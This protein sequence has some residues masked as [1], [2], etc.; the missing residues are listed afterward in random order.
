[1]DT[2]SIWSQWHGAPMSFMQYGQVL[3]IWKD[4]SC[5]NSKSSQGIA[6]PLS[7]LL[8]SL[9]PEEWWR[10]GMRF[11]NMADSLSPHQDREGNEP[12][13]RREWGGYFGLL[14][15]LS[16]LRLR[17]SVCWGQLASVLANSWRAWNLPCQHWPCLSV[18]N[19]YLKCPGSEVLQMLG[20]GGLWI[21]CIHIRFLGDEFQLQTWCF[22]STLYK[23]YVKVLLYNI[24]SAPVFWP[25]H[26]TWSVDFF[27]PGI[28][29]VLK[30][31]SYFKTFWISDLWC[32]HAFPVLWWLLNLILTL[33]LDFWAPWVQREEQRNRWCWPQLSTTRVICWTRAC[34][35]NWDPAQSL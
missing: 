33:N 8:C 20:F 7:F 25:R 14:Y 28:M 23:H 30:N 3:L 9:V 10:M 4:N 18:C 26:L 15:L 19:P 32:H 21:I 35:I 29:L 27:T 31:N 12:S 11:N 16:W 13:K 24:F 34:Y 5:R 22:M 2:Y 17:V 6:L 1:M